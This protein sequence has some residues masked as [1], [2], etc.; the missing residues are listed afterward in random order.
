MSTPGISLANL[1]F[2]FC[3]Y[4]NNEIYASLGDD[5]PYW[6]HTKGSDSRCNPNQ[7]WPK[8]TPQIEHRQ[9]RLL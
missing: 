8:A 7:D 9:E 5:S 1:H 6:Y 3:E 4:C 2:A